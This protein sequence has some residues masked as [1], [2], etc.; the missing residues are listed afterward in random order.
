VVAQTAACLPR[1]RL[2]YF[3]SSGDRSDGRL[4]AVLPCL[5]FRASRAQTPDTRFDAWA[6]MMQ[7]DGYDDE[8][9][10][11]TDLS[12][13]DITGGDDALE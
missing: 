6:E 7:G 12:L 9:P 4:R 1:R 2:V 8:D 13:E 11:A 5:R 3:E 10:E